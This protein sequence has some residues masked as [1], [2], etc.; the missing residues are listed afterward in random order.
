MAGYT[1][2][3]LARKDLDEIWTYTV[4]QWNEEQAERYFRQIEATIEAVA[5]NPNLG[6]GSDEIRRGYFKI[7]SGRT[8]YFIAEPGRRSTSCAFCTNEWMSVAVSN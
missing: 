4:G 8:L 1:L 3:P 2:A 6:L 7:L 5:D